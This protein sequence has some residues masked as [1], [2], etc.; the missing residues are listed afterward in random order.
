MKHISVSAANNL[1][2]CASNSSIHRHKIYHSLFYE[3]CRLIDKLE[4]DLDEQ[5]HDDY[6]KGFL[7]EVRYYRFLLN[8]VPLSMDSQ[9]AQLLSSMQ[10]NLRRCRY[11]FPQ[12]VHH[13]ENMVNKLT[14]LS[15]SHDN[16]LLEAVLGI[17]SSQDQVIAALL[18]KEPYLLPLV[19][20]VLATH[21]ALE[22]IE[23]V[24]QYQ[25]RGAHC[26]NQVIIIGPS[27]WYPEYILRAPRTKEIHLIHYSWLADAR[28]ASPI[29]VKSFTQQQPGSR[30]KLTGDLQ[31][32]IEDNSNELIETPGQDI[33]PEINWSGISTKILRQT[34]EDISQEYIP[35]K[36]YLL[37]SEQAV[38]LDA[39]ENTKVLVLDLE[40]DEDEEEELHQ[41][42][43]IS[44]S[45]V[46]PGMFLLLRTEGGGDYIVPIA[47]RILR[48]K[49][50]PLRAMQDQ[51]K[52]L[53][54]RA[55]ETRGLLAVS[56]ELL[57]YGSKRANETNVR[58]WMSIRSIH[59]HDDEDFRAILKLAGF[60]GK[61]QEYQDAAEQIESAHR[62]AGFYIREQLLKQVPNADLRELHKRGFMD[63]ELP[64]ADGGSL[65]AYRIEH[66]SPEFSSI[67]A[68]RIGRPAT[69]KD[70][71]WH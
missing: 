15:G 68:S 32:R 29:F 66:I 9:A 11:S 46:R 44:L 23:L 61:A 37:A 48:D 14:I 36:L 49:A 20:D 71:L 30:G 57:D 41:I 7:R 62:K 59:P 3:F 21:T 2:I 56:I 6:W 34:Q 19:E 67:P 70:L 69:I 54:K 27:R 33:L 51:W 38:F 5:A 39:N 47:N 63:F 64:E 40:I 65:T 43:R 52:G 1:Y 58:N 45:K 16:P 26:Y 10:D 31:A 53:L 55:V 8:A 24:D 4:Y 60:E 35:A 28:E 18:L 12:F 42:K 13:I 50:L 25:L 22:H 17:V